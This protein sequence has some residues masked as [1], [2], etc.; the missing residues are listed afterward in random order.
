[1]AFQ[2]VNHIAEL[3]VRGVTDGQERVSTFYYRIEN[4]PPTVN[5]LLNL[6]N[7][8]RTTCLPAFLASISHDYSAIQIDVRDLTSQAGLTAS[9]ALVG[10]YVGGRSPSRMASN[11]AVA[12]SRKAAFQGR[13][14]RGWLEM[15]D[16][17]TNDVVK[18]LVQAA[19]IN[20]L[21]QLC[22]VLLQKLVSNTFTP[23]VASRASGQGNNI[24]SWTFDTISDSSRRRLIGRGD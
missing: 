8:F 9:L 19:L 6:A 10:P 11:V 5:D 16:I 3:V 4:Y 18:D 7:A 14:F 13:R 17:A 22:A 20:L 24:H 15:P 21:T 23:V 1:M 2:P 12:L